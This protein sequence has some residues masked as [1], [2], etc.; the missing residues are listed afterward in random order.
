[1]LSKKEIKASKIVAAIWDTALDDQV[2]EAC[3][4]LHNRIFPIYSHELKKIDPPIH[5]GCR[6]RLRYVTQDERGIKERLKEYRPVDFRK[7]KKGMG[8][9]RVIQGNG[10]GK[11]KGKKGKGCLIAFVIVFLI[12][13]VSVIIALVS[14]EKKEPAPTKTETQVQKET[15]EIQTETEES[16]KTQAQAEP[17]ALKYTIVEKEDI[18]YSGTPRMT[19]RVVAEVEKIP[20]NSQLEKM[21][22]RIWENGNKAWKV[23]TVFIYLPGMDTRLA[24]YGVAEFGPQGLKEFRILEAALYGTKW[25]SSK[26]GGNMLTATEPEVKQPAEQEQQLTAGLFSNLTITDVSVSDGEVMIS[27]TTD[28]PNGAS[29]M[30][31]FDVWGRSG[32]DLYIGVGKKITISNGKFKTVLAIPQREEFKKGPYE[33][34]V[35]FTPRGQS[36]RIIQL[37]GKDGEKLRGDLVDDTWTFKT[38]KLVEKKDF[39]LTVAPP[40]Y[41]FQQ[42]SGFPQG[43]AE[44]TVAEYVLAWKEQNWNKMASFAQKT[45]LS[46]ETDP[47]GLLAAWYDFKTL[48]GFEITDVEKVSNVTYDI[49]FVVRY[50]AV[51]NQISKKQITARVIKE[52]TA[53]TPSEQG[54]WGV[55]PISAIRET[56]ID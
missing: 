26:V 47:T 4:S 41:T 43:S 6:C 13:V 35:L 56:D 8:K 51:T 23:F 29:L 16:V 28:L 42:P 5:K 38:M 7:L 36:N 9:K 1:M 39:Q 37:V 21:A 15:K 14:E 44:H 24:A 30:V 18:S 50:E 52:T 48:K 55:N 22:L 27:G 32:S 12:I 31:G 25:E 54:Q 46:T 34:S 17:G 20:S 10:Q 40:S 11:K 45:W 19:F 3:A 33:V 2:C 49:T 53:Y